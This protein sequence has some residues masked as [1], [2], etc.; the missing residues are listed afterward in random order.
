MISNGRKRVLVVDDDTDYLEDLRLLLKP[1]YDVHTA[2]STDS[3]AAL[4]PD[5][6]PH[7]LIL[8]MDMPGHFGD[9]STVEGLAFLRYIRDR[10]GAEP[11]FAVGAVVVS[12]HLTPS[13]RKKFAGCGVAAAM[14]K[15][16]RL[17]ELTDGIERAAAL[18][19]P[20]APA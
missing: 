2:A 3:A 14:E 6:K 8:D 11:A 12:S 16:V 10:I 15:P 5:L 1:A 18:S 4:I 9:N 7:C 17:A 19:E 20:P 13:L